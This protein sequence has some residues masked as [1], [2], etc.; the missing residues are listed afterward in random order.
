MSQ[1]NEVEFDEMLDQFEESLYE[2]SP[3]RFFHVKLM[4]L[5]TK[6]I[7]FIVRKEIRTLFKD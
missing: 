6:S 5:M 3:L 7:Y 4:E 2:R 1:K